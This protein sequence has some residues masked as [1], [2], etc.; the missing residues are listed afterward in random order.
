[1]KTIIRV[2]LPVATVTLITTA[3]AQA[4]FD[5]HIGRFISRDPI[6]ERGGQNIYSLVAN[7]PVGRTDSLGLFCCDGRW[8]SPLTHCCRNKQVYREAFVAT[9]LK[10]CSA[11]TLIQP[12][13]DHLWIEAE[14]W[15]AGFY[16]NGDT[17]GS[18]PGQ[19]QYP[20][21]AEDRPNKR[22]G[23]VTLN[24]CQ[25]DF[26]CFKQ[27][28]EAFV[29]RS[30]ANPPNYHYLFYNCRNWVHET[31]SGCMEQCLWHKPPPQ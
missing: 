16:P 22:C 24:P 30:R 4:F 21:P 3:C 27:C 28:V 12:K 9:G 2:D 5:P 6:G 11:P 8:Y 7:N 18:L 29:S 17:D 10:T 19:V 25:H 31:I 15:S 13:V 20:D 14:G 26:D 1:M 23:P